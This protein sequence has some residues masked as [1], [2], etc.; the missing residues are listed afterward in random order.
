MVLK[1]AKGVLCIHVGMS[2]S[3]GGAVDCL[4]CPCLVLT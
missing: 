3:E 4:P 2:H 1:D